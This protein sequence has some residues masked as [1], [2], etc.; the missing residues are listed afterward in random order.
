MKH[1]FLTLLSIM[2]LA[3]CGGSPTPVS[4]NNGGNNN[5]GNGNTG[6]VRDL[7]PP[8]DNFDFGGVKKEDVVQYLQ[9]N[10]MGDRGQ[11]AVYENNGD[12]QLSFYYVAA[13]DSF[14]LVNKTIAHAGTATQTTL[15]GV[16]FQ[17]GDI[18]RGAFVCSITYVNGS[19]VY[20]ATVKYVVTSGAFLECPQMG[21]Y[22]STDVNY[23]TFPTGLRASVNNIV[24]T[25]WLGIKAVVAYG[26]K[27]CKQIKEGCHL[28][29]CEMQ[30]NFEQGDASQKQ[31][32]IQYLTSNDDYGDSRVGHSTTLANKDIVHLWYNPADDYFTVRAYKISKESDD[33]T[34]I[35]SWDFRFGSF[36]RGRQD[37]CA[38]NLEFSFEEGTIYKY[39]R[40]SSNLITLKSDH[41]YRVNEPIVTSVDDPSWD[42]VFTAGLSMEILDTAPEMMEF[43]QSEW[44]AASISFK[45]W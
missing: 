43:L 27:V 38:E 2:L 30:T 22:Y 45:L 40:F 13:D 31:S 36:L 35:S 11:A 15:S 41:T 1:K 7:V 9:D 21:S 16:T 17:W 20:E 10:N 26:E 5:G 23:G 34:V 4:P 44:S 29:N 39:V 14:N 37:H 32:F 6:G 33:F 42:S 3:S 24:N 12:M 28:W 8:T 18:Y 19:S 25:Q